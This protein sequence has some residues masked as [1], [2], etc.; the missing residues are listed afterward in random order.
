[1][2]KTA[3]ELRASKA[4]CLDGSF[5]AGKSH[6]MAVSHLLLAGNPEARSIPE[7]GNQISAHAAWMEG[8]KFLMVPF[9]FLAAD[10]IESALFKGYTDLVL[11]QFPNKP[12][13]ALVTSTALL[14]NAAQS[15]ASM[16]D[17]KFFEIL[18]RGAAG[19]GESGGWGELG[20]GWSSEIFRA[21]GADG[22]DLGNRAVAMERTYARCDGTAA[23]GIRLPESGHEHACGF[24]PRRADELVHVWRVDGEPDAVP[25]L[26]GVLWLGE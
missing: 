12:Y 19:A 18:N 26:Y 6:F 7:L 5:G 21:R 17:A 23:A 8:K 11:K 20:S 2:V 9:H 16:G 3:V 4:A 13:P 24:C 15:R 22:A 1:M 10:S 14:Q 25:A